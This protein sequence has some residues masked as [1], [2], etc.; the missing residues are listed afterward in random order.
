MKQYIKLFEDFDNT[1]LITVYHGDNFGTTKIDPINMDLKGN[2]QEG[3]GIYF[4]DKLEVAEFYG[5]HIVSAQI[6]PDRFID[7]RGDIGDYLESKQMVE[8]FKYLWKI[9]P[10]QMYYLITDYVEVWEPKD[11]TERHLKILSQEMKTE[12]VRNFQITLAQTFDVRNF[13]DSWN[14]NIKNIDGT[15]NSDLGFYCIINPKIELNIY[16]I[17]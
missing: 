2:M 9:N 14:L 10:E 16:S 4:A 12:E 13:V 15:V 11:L 3:V 17:S 5:K 7:S 6:S 1:Q 8:M